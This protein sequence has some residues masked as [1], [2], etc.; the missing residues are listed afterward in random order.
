MLTLLQI[1]SYY[2]SVGWKILTNYKLYIILKNAVKNRPLFLREASN[3]KRNRCGGICV[4]FS[5]KSTSFL[6]FQTGKNHTVQLELSGDSKYVIYVASF[7]MSPAICW[8]YH[9]WFADSTSRSQLWSSLQAKRIDLS[10]LDPLKNLAER[11]YSKSRGKYL[12]FLVLST[13]SNGK[14][15]WWFPFYP[16]VLHIQYVKT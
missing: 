14:N 4:N 11:E 16:M 9:H 7:E 13:L 10:H 2:L 8:I 1:L 6:S 12:R 3:V 5:L 15:C